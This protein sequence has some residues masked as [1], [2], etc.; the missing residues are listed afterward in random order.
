MARD[1]DIESATGHQTESI[2][3]GESRGRQAV[4]SEQEFAERSNTSHV[5]CE[6][7]TNHDGSYVS[8]IAIVAASVE[9]ESECAIEIPGG[10]YRP[11]GRHALQVHSANLATG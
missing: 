9:G 4:Q 1:A 2:V 10:S 7:R 8:V 11:P 5:Q 3:I 6:L